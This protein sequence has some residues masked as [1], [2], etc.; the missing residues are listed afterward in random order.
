M[1]RYALVLL[2][3]APGCRCGGGDS[4]GGLGDASNMLLATNSVVGVTS[5]VTGIEQLHVIVQPVDLP[6]MGGTCAY[7][8]ETYEGY[9]PAVTVGEI[10]LSAAVNTFGI[11][12]TGTGEAT[13]D[14]GSFDVSGVG[15]INCMIGVTVEALG[16]GGTVVAMGGSGNTVFAFY[17]ISDGPRLP[18]IILQ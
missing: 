12:W 3:L 6:N 13:T 16:T 1:L 8:G 7:S 11:H 18:T 14:I 15:Q 10:D 5:T 9:V 2:L 17:G 4:D